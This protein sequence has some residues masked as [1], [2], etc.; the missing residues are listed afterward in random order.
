M[1]IIDEAK[2]AINQNDL[3]R[4]DDIWT[5]MVLDE[6]LALTAFFDI[7]H[8]LKEI[9]QADHALLLLEMLAA[10]CE[11]NNEYR[12]AIEVYRQTA[13]YRKDSSGI[14]KKLAEL[15]RKQHVESTHIDDYIGSSGL[16]TADSLF[17][18]LDKLDEYLTY[19]VGQY[20]YFERYGLGQVV[21]TNPEK[22]EI[23][24]DFEKKKRHFLTLDIARGL[25]MP[26]DHEHFLYKKAKNIEELRQMAAD[27][28]EELVLLLLHS[29]KDPMTPAQIK[30][31]LSS[32]VEE[33]NI[34]GFWERTRKVLEKNAYVRLTAKPQKKYAV[35]ES[36]T[37]RS[38]LARTAFA[39]ASP[40]EKYALAE[41]YSRTM[42]DVFSSLGLDLV[43]LGS[44]IKDKDPALALD[45]LLLCMRNSPNLTFN[46]TLETILDKNDASIVE[47]MRT[48]KHQKI[49]LEHIVQNRSGEWPGIF[50]QLL[51]SA[52]DHK[53]LDE[54]GTFLTRTPDVLSDTYRTIFSFPKKYP[55]QYR[56][57]LKKIQNG[58]LSEY[59]QPGFLPRMIESLDYVKG[60][61]GILNKILAL[62]RFDGIMSRA[63]H[64]EAER[65]LRT[66]NAS[67]M[68]E[69]YRKKDFERIIQHHQP[70]LFKKDRMEVYTTE[71]AL[72]R[73]KQELE[74]LVKVEIPANKKEISRAREFGDLSENFEYKA[75]REK[76]GQLMEKVRILESDLQQAKVI[77]RDTVD[78]SRV[79]VG[80]RVSLIRITDKTELQ[81][82]ILGRWDTDLEKNII[83]NEAPVAQALLDKAC[84]DRVTIHGEEYEI[85]Y[86]QIAL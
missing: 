34:T 70:S 24:V 51:F 86:I 73:K 33:K 30:R 37:D 25:L 53:L 66:V 67:T 74:H 16:L 79:S 45:I 63:S 22:Q 31:H 60:V 32:I 80:T 43:R 10:Q 54:L 56:W 61:K 17:K 55:H 36:G 58:D 39:D 2:E 82:T 69:E 9:Q 81:Y 26:I 5:D 46:Y 15:Y 65:I 48:T 8:L 84:G 20:F 83:S 28:P 38:D 41:E 27:H 47:Q 1:S 21:E 4:L 72:I 3:K 44:S 75:A 68:L 64:D 12:K 7:A 11:S 57:M 59:A 77:D 23:I 76:Q 19:D 29:M 35:I 14:R 6:H 18:A 78:T 50:Q 52:S 42:P 13:Y 71:P 40:N 85:R 49:V 62:E